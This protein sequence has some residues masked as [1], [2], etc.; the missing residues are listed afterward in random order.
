MRAFVPVTVAATV[1][2]A[3]V[4]GFA[5]VEVDRTLSRVYG[6]AIMLSDVRQAGVLKLVPE[7]AAGDDAVQAALE[8]RLLVLREV[9]RGAPAEPDREAVAARRRAWTAS[10]PPGAD[11]AS[12]MARVGMS[13]QALDGWFRDDL[14]MAAYLDQRFGAQADAARAAR[15]A[16]WIADLRRRANL[17]GKINEP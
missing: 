12:A 15:I 13:D 1:L 9:A 10:W 6:A 11:L 5:Q 14:L 4:S 7:A 17:P 8:N 2:M 3:G 16:A